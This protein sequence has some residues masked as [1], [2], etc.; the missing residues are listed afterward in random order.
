MQVFFIVIAVGLAG[1]PAEDWSLPALNH[2]VESLLARTGE[3]FHFLAK[4]NKVLR[5]ST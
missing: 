1:E 5:V 2:I 4:L 3:L